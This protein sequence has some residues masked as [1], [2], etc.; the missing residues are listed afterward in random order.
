MIEM[1]GVLAIVGILSAGGIA[2]YSM[3]MQNHK[4]NTFIEK[5][6]IMVQ[7]IR[8]L[9]EGD[10]TPL[11]PNSLTA[12]GVIK[13]NNNPFGGTFYIYGSGDRGFY[14][15]TIDATVPK[16]ACVKIL[17]ADWGQTGVFWGVNTSD[18]PNM[19]L[20]WERGNCLSTLPGAILKCNSENNDIKLWFK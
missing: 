8:T 20:A 4:T 15:T 17:S 2:G 6:Q 13:D 5:V 11:R 12:A 1:L 16:D 10:Y 9:Y 19:A 14:I 18:D 3:A 7:E